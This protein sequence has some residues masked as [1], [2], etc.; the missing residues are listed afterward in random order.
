MELDD[1]GTSYFSLDPLPYLND[2]EPTAHVELSVLVDKVLI[3]SQ[4][5]DQE[6]RIEF[7]PKTGDVAGWNTLVSG[8]KTD[9]VGF[10]LAELSK[11]ETEDGN[12][13]FSR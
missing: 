2:M 3:K 7:M 13:K 6:L 1:N 9:P 12:G 11:Q 8:I 10:L 4:D 5:G